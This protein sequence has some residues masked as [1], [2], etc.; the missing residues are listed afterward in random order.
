MAAIAWPTVALVGRCITQ[1]E[2]PTGGF[3]FSVRQLGLLWRSVWLSASATTLCMLISIPTA[4]VLGNRRRWSDRPMMVG[5]MMLLLLT[6][7][8]VCAFGWERLLPGT[9][10]AHVRCIVLWAMWAWPI[11]SMIIGAGWSRSARD[12][13]EAATLVAS[14]SVAFFRVAL[15][16]LARYVVVG[17]AIVFLLC[18]RDYGVPHACGL[19]VFST[20]L[21][22]WAR[23]S[24]N[25]IDTVWPSLPVVLGTL[26]MLTVALRADWFTTD[27]APGTDG[28][29]S[30]QS[31][32][33]IWLLAVACFIGAWL[34][35]VGTLAIK[36]ASL[37][38]MAE[39]VRTYGGDI[40]WSLA[41]G[42]GC[43]LVVAVAGLG[44]MTQPKCRGAMLVWA[45]A[46][47]ALP[48][49]LVGESLVA[50]YN[51]SATAWLYDHWPI[52]AL[53]YVARFAWVGLAAGFL[54]MRTA[55]SLL[56][57]QADTDG[58]SF[59][60]RWA[61][62]YVPLGLP[63]LLCGAVIVMALSLGELEASSLVR[64]PSFTPISHVII[65][66]FHRFEYGM[67]IS[68]SLWLVAAAAA[69][70]MIITMVLRRRQA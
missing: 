20:E 14:P 58:A 9:V 10:D 12:V 7:P 67:L 51:F 19:L 42:V 64:V 68:L 2:P 4:Y 43:G 3:G 15:P 30:R 44:L 53:S 21:L 8:M 65:E 39:A 49:A 22:G 5:A 50:A 69:A 55:S 63:V 57:D 59:L 16:S 28:P 1:G 61:R 38:A 46:F 56:G 47:G 66:K 11:S 33:W 23:D 35:P 48:G 41:L 54:V 24:A 40:A 17:A 62:I 29:T 6:S 34:I 45:L 37:G 13:Y 31:S 36:L 18:L 52:V 27:D 32:H 26:V 25:T 60:Q 70:A